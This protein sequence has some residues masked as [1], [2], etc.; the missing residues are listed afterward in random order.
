MTTSKGNLSA[1]VAARLN[2][3]A[4]QSGDDY[5]T[6]LTAFCFERLL[7]R[8]GVSAASALYSRVRGSC[9]SVT[10]AEAVRRTFE[11]R[12]TPIPAATPIALTS[13]YRENPSRPDQVRS[14]ARRAG[15]TLPDDPGREFT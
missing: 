7:Y 5:Q 1:S 6:V 2:N 3:R 15:L 8:L 12:G 9:A 4:R 13:A 11:S 14:F 10:L